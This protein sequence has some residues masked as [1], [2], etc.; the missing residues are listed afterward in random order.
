MRRDAMIA[1]PVLLLMSCG[2]QPVSVAQTIA[3]PT[4]SPSPVYSLTAADRAAV[5]KLEARPLRFAAPPKDGTCVDGPHTD[6]IGPYAGAM[7][8]YSPYGK[9]PVYGQGSP[10]TLTTRNA[11]FHV[12]YFTAPAVHGV[13]LVRIEQLGGLYKGFFAGPLGVGKVVG[14]DN[15]DGVDMQLY[16]ELA[17]PADNPPSNTGAAAGWGIWKVWQGLD[18]HFTCAGIQIDFGSTTE[19]ITAPGP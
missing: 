2:G 17:L 6:S 7:L 15:I 1:F 10:V 8:E 9:G 12:T 4:P 14:T 3:S 18:R 13:V 5:T 11:L 16:S 19:I